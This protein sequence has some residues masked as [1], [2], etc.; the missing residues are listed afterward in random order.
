MLLDEII[1]ASAEYLHVYPLRQRRVSVASA[2][3][4]HPLA[5]GHVLTLRSTIHKGTIGGALK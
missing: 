5:P 4:I 2:L 1:A 3:H